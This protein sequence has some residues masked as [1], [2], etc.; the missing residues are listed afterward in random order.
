MPSVVQHGPASLGPLTRA[1]AFCHKTTGGGR[2]DNAP[3]A[4]LPVPYFLRQLEDF[5]AGRRHSSDPRKSNTQTM[6]ALAKA[7]SQ[8]EQVAAA[9]YYS[10]QRGVFSSARD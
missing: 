6:I 9:T 5:C 4:G 3:I 1:C 10:A 2:P 7:M 8:D